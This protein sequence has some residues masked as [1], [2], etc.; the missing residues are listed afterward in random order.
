MDSS[1]NDIRF[2]MELF[3]FK[4][5][6]RGKLFL[7]VAVVEVGH[8]ISHLKSEDVTH[9]T[10]TQITCLCITY[11]LTQITCL[12]I[13]YLLTHKLPTSTCRSREEIERGYFGDVRGMCN[14][15]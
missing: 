6:F 15:S 8:W 1:L 2:S 3:S 12:Y 4:W 7:S 10:L 14:S 5:S 11:L 9:V 13:T